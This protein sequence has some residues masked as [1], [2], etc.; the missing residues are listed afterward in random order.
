MRQRRQTG[1]EAERKPPESFAS[2]IAKGV[3][4]VDFYQKVDTD[5]VQIEQTS[6][7]ALLSLITTALIIYLIC[8]EVADYATVESTHHVGVDPKGGRDLH[9]TFNISFHN[10]RCEH[11][12]LQSQ[13][14]TGDLQD[15]ATLSRIH[16]V[17]LGASG[18]PISTDSTGE[19]STM[20]RDTGCRLNGTLVLRKV[21]GNFHIALGHA[22]KMPNGALVHRFKVSD[23]RG[24]KAAH[25]IH[26]LSFGPEF[27][28]RINPLDNHESGFKENPGHYQYFIKV[29]PTT[30]IS[31]N[32]NSI[33]SAQF[34][35]TS[36]QS[37]IRVE[38]IRRHSARIIP[39]VMTNK[40]IITSQIRRKRFC[41][42]I[43]CV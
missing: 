7:G 3:R 25:T 28:T 27:P 38:A 26:H 30:F 19:K 32:R 35:V 20:R 17:P 18:H 39:G 15:V 40:L 9:A 14:V 36:Q 24:F 34:A 16:K 6:V 11:L 5:E 2:R 23:I 8:A 31:L 22:E 41:S 4:R 12:S 10:L 29:V 42:G 13:D 33:E 37:E 43:L 1:A 21:K